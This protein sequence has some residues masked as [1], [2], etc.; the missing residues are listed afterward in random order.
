MHDQLGCTLV[1]LSIQI[2]AM[3]QQARESMAALRRTLAGLRA[4]SWVG[5]RSAR[6]CG[7]AALAERVGLSCLWFI[8][9]TVD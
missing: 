3:K 2:E 9:L 4:R 8:R 7:S 6:F 5:K 1:A